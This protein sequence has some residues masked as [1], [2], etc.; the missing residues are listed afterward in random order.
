MNEWL[1]VLI[2]ILIKYLITNLINL[3]FIFNFK[4]IIN[5]WFNKYSNKKI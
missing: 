2:K 1:N 4:K 3:D 5:E